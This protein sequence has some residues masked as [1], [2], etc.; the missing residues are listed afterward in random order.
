MVLEHRSVAPVLIGFA[1]VPSM[2]GLIYLI[3]SL[4]HGVMR[5]PSAQSSTEN[6]TWHGPFFRRVTRGCSPVPVPDEG[7]NKHGEVPE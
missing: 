1:S 6:G 3:Q 2:A 7:P 4:R 5:C